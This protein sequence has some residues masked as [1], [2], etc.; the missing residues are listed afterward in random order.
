MNITML[1]RVRKLFDFGYVP[2]TT[3]RHNQ[4]EWIRSIRV[5]G[6]SWILKQPIQRKQNGTNP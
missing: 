1:V 2:T 3:R 4:R 6:D 5:L